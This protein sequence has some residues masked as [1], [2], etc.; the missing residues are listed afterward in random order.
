MHT[1][2][3]DLG[4]SFLTSGIQFSLSNLMPAWLLKPGSNGHDS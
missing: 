1:L 2:V 4:S 3:M